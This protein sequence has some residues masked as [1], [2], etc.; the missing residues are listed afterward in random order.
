MGYGYVTEKVA[1][2]KGG[3]VARRTALT[4]QPTGPDGGIPPTVAVVTRPVLANTMVTIAVP[5]D[6][7]PQART[8]A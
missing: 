7:V 3:S 4:M 2:E 1:R 6:P 5:P 8:A